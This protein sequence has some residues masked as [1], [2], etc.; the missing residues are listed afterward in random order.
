MHSDQGI[1]YS[2][3]GY[4]SLLKGY[5]VIQ[6]MSRAGTPRNNAVTESFFGRFKDVL[7][8]K[9]RYWQ[10]ED[11]QQTISDAITYFNKERPVRKL[12]GKTPVQYRI[13]LTL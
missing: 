6:S 4:S 13:E 3:A 10:Q 8:V 9:F 5:N 11:L 1:Q 12:N 7:R 2:S